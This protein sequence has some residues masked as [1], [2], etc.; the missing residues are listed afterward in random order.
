MALLAL[1]AAAACDSP[2]GLGDD[3]EGDL[4][5]NRELWENRG[6]ASYDLTVR[7][8]CFCGFV[9]PVRVMVRNGVRTGVI[10]VSSGDPVTAPFADHFPDVPGLFDIVEDAIERDA[11]ELEVRYDPTLGVPVHIE[12]DYEEN[13]IDEE[14]TWDVLSLVPR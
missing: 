13:T 11:H 6:F 7:Q 4:E 5:D 9:E 3:G 8:L 14:V 2:F 1:F 10:V 12:I